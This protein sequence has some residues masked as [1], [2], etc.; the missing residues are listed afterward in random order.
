M[1]KDL[2]NPK[3]IE[4]IRNQFL[5]AQDNF[6]P[7]LFQPLKASDSCLDHDHSTQLCRGALHKQSNVFEG[8]VTNAYKRC[9][10]WLSDDTL[11]NVLRRLAN[12]YESEPAIKAY[13][14]DWIKRVV[15]DFKKLDSKSQEEVLR[16]I[17]SVG[18]SNIKQRVKLFRKK[19]TK[20]KLGYEKVSSI[21]KRSN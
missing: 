16:Q 7:I 14:S 17:D 21:L 6:D 2:Y 20:E 12:Y 15:I 13:H 4:Y 1:T 5:I 18:G 3:D 10:S 19:I 9:I 11:S 8:L